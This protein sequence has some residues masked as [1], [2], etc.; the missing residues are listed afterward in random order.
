M[1]ERN[2]WIVENEKLGIKEGYSNLKKLIAL[3]PFTYWE[4]YFQVKNKGEYKYNDYLVY[5]L[6]IN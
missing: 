3:Y 1:R 2:D 5:K 4:V 6:K